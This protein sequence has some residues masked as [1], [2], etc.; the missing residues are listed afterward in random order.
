MK[1]KFCCTWSWWF[2]KIGSWK[3]YF[4]W[5]SSCC[6]WFTITRTISITPPTLTVISIPLQSTVRTTG[7]GFTW[8]PRL[9]NIIIVIQTQAWGTGTLTGVI[10]NLARKYFVP[11]WVIVKLEH[12]IFILF[13]HT[14]GELFL[15]CVSIRAVAL[16][17]TSRRKF[18]LFSLNTDTWCQIIWCQSYSI[19]ATGIG[20]TWVR[21]WCTA[22]KYLCVSKM[23]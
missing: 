16:K 8:I 1:W 23:K 3:I 7:V 5:I 13:W 22:Y 17:L 11:A 20:F 21:N 10:Q 9:A 4:C 15:P 18:W 2:W 12:I 19:L 14:S 6:S